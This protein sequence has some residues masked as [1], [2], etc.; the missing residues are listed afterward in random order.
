MADPPKFE[1]VFLRD[2]GHQRQH[3]NGLEVLAFAQ[4][5]PIPKIDC[6]L[7]VAFFYFGYLYKLFYEF[8]TPRY[9]DIYSFSSSRVT[10]LKLTRGKSFK[11][12]KSNC[13][14][15]LKIAGIDSIELRQDSFLGH[16]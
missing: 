14:V 12:K 16:V 11:D 10:M 6:Y 2:S 9:F 7:L 8:H 3:E 1:T 4:I 13:W 5:F 15:F